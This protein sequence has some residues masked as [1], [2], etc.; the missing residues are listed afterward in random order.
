MS[1]FQWRSRVAVVTGA[2]AGIGAALVHD[3]APQGR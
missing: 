3:L 2:S 1:A